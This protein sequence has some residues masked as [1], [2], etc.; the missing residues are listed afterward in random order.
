MNT[1]T[2]PHHGVTDFVKDV[3]VSFNKMGFAGFVWLIGVAVPTTYAIFKAGRETAA[4]PQAFPEQK[5][6]IQGLNQ[7]IANQK[8]AV[9]QKDKELQR[10]NRELTELAGKLDLTTRRLQTT[11]AEASRL[12]HDLNLAAARTTG[13]PSIEQA[14]D[15]TPAAQNPATSAGMKPASAVPAAKSIST[16]RKSIELVAGRPALIDHTLTVTLNYTRSFGGQFVINGS[17]YSSQTIGARIDVSA[18]VGKKCF[19]E[20]MTLSPDSVLPQTA[21]LDYVCAGA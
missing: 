6:A 20:V 8:V 10:L 21:Q 1:S 15:A 16:Q 11:E 12:K 14:K 18:A 9:D 19:L 4:A 2:P 7:V 3:S 13:S 17:K 5:E